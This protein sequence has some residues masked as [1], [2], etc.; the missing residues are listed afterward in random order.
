[1]LTNPQLLFSTCTSKGHSNFPVTISLPKLLPVMQGSGATGMVSHS[2]PPGVCWAL[3]SFSLW[4]SIHRKSI[5][6]VPL[7]ETQSP[8]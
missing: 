4:F 8:G 3:N 2:I 1:M 6:Q 5:A 7:W